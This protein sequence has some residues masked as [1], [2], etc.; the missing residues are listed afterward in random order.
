M[1]TALITGVTS[2]IGH[3]LA[4]Y[5]LQNGWRVLGTYRSFIPEDLSRFGQSFVPLQG[6]LAIPEQRSILGAS[7]IR[8]FEKTGL[9]LLIN[10]AGQA[11]PGPLELLPDEEF[12]YQM[13]LNLF[14]VKEITDLCIPALK[15]SKGIIVNISSV[16]G[17]FNTPFMGAYCISKHALESMTEIYRRE[18]MLFGIK[19]VSIAPGPIKT[20]IWKKNMGS[21]TRFGTE[22]P[23]IPY[24]KHADKMIQSTE[25]YALPVSHVIDSLKKILKSDD[26]KAVYF[27]HKTLLR[28]KFVAFL[29]P[30]KWIDKMI[31]K[32]MGGSENFRPI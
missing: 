9:D 24:L 18:L 16:S 6:D 5:L 3:A 30:K 23:Y 10:N 27:I 14:S 28:F 2:G 4:Q 19:V 26:P 11:I 25:D 22:H 21:M 13:E 20:L 29:I 31:L 32:K 17:Y 12:R 15:R 8:Q 7:L 1:K